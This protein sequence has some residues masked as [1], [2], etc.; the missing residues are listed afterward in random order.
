L[1]D[2]GPFGGR[3]DPATPVDPERRV[4]AWFA[5]GGGTSRLLAGTIDGLVVGLAAATV[6]AGPPIV[7][8]I[9]C[10]YVEPAARGVGVGASLVTALIGWFT[11]TG[12]SGVDA[13]ALPGDREMK[14]LLETA[15]FKTRLLVLHRS[16]S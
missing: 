8:R 14:Q 4:A 9:E 11:D 16:P 7:G 1:A 15:G 5:D 12:C 6:R 13:L 10:C 2:L 3:D